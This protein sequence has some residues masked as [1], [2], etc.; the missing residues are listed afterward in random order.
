MKAKLDKDNYG[1]FI[2][3]KVD[4]EKVRQ[5]LMQNMQSF[6]SAAKEHIFEFLYT[7][8]LAAGEALFSDKVQDKDN[9]MKIL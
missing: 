6:G 3:L 8:T 5:E 1:S 4:I 7:K 2:D 9:K